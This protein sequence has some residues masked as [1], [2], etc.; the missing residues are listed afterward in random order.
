MI[1]FAHS[2]HDHAIEVTQAA[3]VSPSM[4]AIGGIVFLFVAA[5][6]FLFLKQK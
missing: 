1:F 3:S 4:M 6:L 5:C 2:G